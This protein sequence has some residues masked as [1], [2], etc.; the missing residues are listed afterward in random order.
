MPK[1]KRLLTSFSKGE[2]SPRLEGRADLAAYFE[3]AKTLENWLLLRQGG[4][5]RRSG[6]RYMA[7]V[8]DSTRDTILIPFEFS[9]DDAFHLEFGH[10]YIR[11]YKNNQRIE[12]AGVPVEIVSPYQE[13]DLRLIHFTQ[14]ADVLFLFHPS[15]AQRKLS[16]VSD[17]QWVLS[18]VPYNPMPSFDADTVLTDPTWPLIFMYSAA[19][20]TNVRCRAAD[21]SLDIFPDAAI[22]LAADVG[23]QII[24]GAGRAVITSLIDQYQVMV[25]ILDD[26]DPTPISAG[27]GVLS[28]V[29]TNV[30]TTIAHGVSP[31]QFISVA[32]GA[33]SGQAQKVIATPSLTTMTI[34]YAFPVDQNGVDWKKHIPIPQGEWALRGSPQ[35]T[36][37]PDKKEPVGAQI[38]LDAG[39]EAFRTTNRGTDVGKFVFIYGGL[40]K[41]T[42]WISA[43]QVKGEILTILADTT[44]ANPAA[45]PAGAWILEEASWSAARGF[46]RTGEFFQGRLGQAATI[47]QPTDFWLSASDSF[48]NYAVGA[49]ADDAIEYTIASRRVNRIV[50]L[51]DIGDFFVGTAGAEFRVVGERNGEPLGGD[52]IPLVQRVS[53]HGGAPVQPAIMDRQILFVDR[54]TLK[55]F[56]IS[57]S[58][59]Q[60]AF[61]PI[62][63]TAPSDHITGTGIRLGPLGVRNRLDPQIFF[64]REDGTLLALTFF[65]HEKVI[66]FTRLTTDGLVQAVSV[67]PRATKQTDQVA[68]IVQ[69]TINGQMKRFV[70]YFDENASELSSRAWPSLQTDCAK[71]YSGAATTTITGLSHLEGKTVDI[72]AD[73]SFRGTKVV[74]SGT[75]TLDEAASVVELGLHYDSLGVT[76]RPAISDTV[77]EG[78]PRSWD[79][80]SIRLLDTMGGKV[81]SE[82][83]QYVPSDLDELGLFTGDRK[84]VGQGWDTDGRITFEQTQPYPITIL[85]VYGTLSVGDHV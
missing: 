24:V 17:T 27:P 47:S 25:D 51:A 63:L 83:L 16:R 54:S 79:D 20:G 30:T 44:A 5:T 66:G 2:I 64:V 82:W 42:Q 11:F 22:F 8:K 19:T 35:T 72:V 32:S 31:G 68:V 40:V 4:V 1:V 55:I 48:E 46:P 84:I 43:T 75:V 6:T 49:N 18:I 67:I 7:E 77:I 73:G 59:E 69:R 58:L 61:D 10:Q 85:A 53:T 9:V 38:T 74:I 34:E 39:A 15:Y 71:V 57:Y 12:V 21:N 62:E 41:I 14:S 36:L 28:T 60:D 3:G 37:D 29:G 80:V 45:A 65:P 33:E 50:W 76:M 56:A 52:K 26:F 23:R 13:A 81:N 70:E 78:L